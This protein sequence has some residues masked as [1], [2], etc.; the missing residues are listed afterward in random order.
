MIYAILTAAGS[1]KRFNHK[2]HKKSLPKQF[3]IIHRKP[4]ILYSLLAL[5]QCK[6]VNEIIITLNEEYVDMRDLNR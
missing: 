1:G 3:I 6:E 5:Q 4:V 2:A